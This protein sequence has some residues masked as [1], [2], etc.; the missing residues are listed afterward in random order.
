MILIGMFIGFV[1][2]IFAM[3][4]AA[5]SGQANERTRAMRNEERLRRIAS[6]WYTTG[7]ITTF[8]KKEVED[9]IEEF[10]KRSK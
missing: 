8:P 7:L 1:F 4:I 10:K 2:G 6:W 3:A 5:S 9:W